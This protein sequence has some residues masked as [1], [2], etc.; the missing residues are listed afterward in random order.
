M[1][2]KPIVIGGGISG[3]STAYY[4]AKGGVRST[5]LESRRRMG[6]VIHTERVDG[7]TLEAGPDSFLSVCAN[8]AA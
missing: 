5:L 2:D 3:L 4:L 7:C 8:A 1:P 6:G